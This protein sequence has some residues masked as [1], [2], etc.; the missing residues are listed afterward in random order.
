[1]RLAPQI[2]E[3]IGLLVKAG[4]L[5]LGGLGTSNE[6]IAAGG[7]VVS[8]ER[9]KHSRQA[10][11]GGHVVEPGTPGAA[12][13]PRGARPVAPSLGGV[14]L[15]PRHPGIVVPWR[16]HPG[17]GLRQPIGL[18]GGIQ[19]H[20]EGIPG[21]DALGPAPGDG[22]QRGQPLFGLAVAD[23]G[24]SQGEHGVQVVG[25]GTDD[26]REQ[27]GHGAG[28]GRLDILSDQLQ[29]EMDAVVRVRLDLM[30]PE[31]QPACLFRAPS[32]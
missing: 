10:V 30:L 23:Q 1:M 20:Q 25:I 18:A 6:A 5:R 11:G 31:R 19:A 3:G 7:L 13:G 16:R 32:R 26:R 22:V 8:S 9:V 17:P 4:K 24:S 28:L 14:P 29:Q 15:V 21:V 12:V 2:L 27:G